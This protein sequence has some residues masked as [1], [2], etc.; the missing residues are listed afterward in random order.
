MSVREVDVKLQ[1]VSQACSESDAGFLQEDKTINH[2]TSA[3]DA[4]VKSVEVSWGD[5]WLIT[6]QSQ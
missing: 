4:G 5:E 2:L 1:C 6:L 3:S